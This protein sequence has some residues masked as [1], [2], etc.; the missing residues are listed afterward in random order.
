MFSKG[1][2]SYKF[3]KKVLDPEMTQ[4][5][6]FEEVEPLI[7]EYISLPGRNA[8]LLAYGQTGTGKTHTI[9]GAKEAQLDVN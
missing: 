8:M 4:Q 1:E 3:P 9:F 2:N 5:Q 7:N 6:V